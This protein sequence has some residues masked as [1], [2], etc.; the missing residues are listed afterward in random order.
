MTDARPGRG[1]LHSDFVGSWIW[2]LED[3]WSIENAS[4]KGV[5]RVSGQE[6]GPVFRLEGQNLKSDPVGKNIV[7]RLTCWNRS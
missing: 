5:W 3:F 7:S 6:T 4:R 2:N 1:L